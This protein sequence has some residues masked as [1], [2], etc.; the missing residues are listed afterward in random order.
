M[1]YKLH[2][3]LLLNFGLGYG[4]RSN[5]KR[6]AVRVRPKIAANARSATCDWAAVLLAAAAAAAAA[7]L[8]GETHGDGAP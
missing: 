4:S 7:R 8:I 6:R 5:S 2:L 3:S 1:D